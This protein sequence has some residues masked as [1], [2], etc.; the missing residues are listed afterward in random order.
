MRK[1]TFVIVFV[2]STLT[3]FAQ[4]TELN[5]K[6]L[7]TQDTVW[8]IQI[9]STR[10]VHLVKPEMVAMME[11]PA[12]VEP[13]HDGWNRI[14]IPYATLDEAETS[15]LTWQRAHDNAFILPRTGKKLAKMQSLFTWK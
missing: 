5:L 4:R 9:F 13:A 8:C 11:E 6:Q 7:A 14:L 2:V 1:L 15:L 3:L 10:N 12:M